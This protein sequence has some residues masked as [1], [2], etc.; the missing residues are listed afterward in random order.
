MRRVM[1]TVIAIGLIV[2]TVAGAMVVS[3][4]ATLVATVGRPVA[5]PWVALLPPALFRAI[6]DGV[7]GSQ[8]GRFETPA[9]L[10]L[11]GLCAMAAYAI[12]L[13]AVPARDLG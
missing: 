5:P 11:A 3:T 6:G 9:L 7:A 1:R 10:A 13:R 12:W 2:V 8:I 4:A